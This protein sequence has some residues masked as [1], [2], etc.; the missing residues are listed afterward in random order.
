MGLRLQLLLALASADISSP[1]PAELM[2]IFYCLSFVTPP[3]VEGQVPVF[4]SPRKSVAQLY[5]QALCFLL[6]ASYESQGYSRGIRTRL[7][8]TPRHGSP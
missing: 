2:A 5:P 1:S 6:V 3:N 8:T 7:L 4:I